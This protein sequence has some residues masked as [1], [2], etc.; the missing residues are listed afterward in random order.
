M[1]T[2]DIREMVAK[3][4][5]EAAVKALIEITTTDDLRQM[6]IEIAASYKS[7]KRKIISGIIN[8]EQ[9]SQE[10]AIITHRVLY[11]VSEYELS[12]IK[13]LKDNVVQLKEEVKKLELP[14]SES[15][16][17]A[18]DKIEGGLKNADIIESK[19]EIEGGII[20][21]IKQLYDRLSDPESI[22]NKIIK[23]I[24]EGFVIAGKIISI[25]RLIPL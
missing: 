17:D 11:L 12:Q 19:K 4:Q 18:L 7:Y 1:T 5:L 21:K 24:K 10:Y 23:N 25:V 2:D 22:E 6:S 3:A 20:K 14:E 16:I 9:Q 8:N 15:L 13:L